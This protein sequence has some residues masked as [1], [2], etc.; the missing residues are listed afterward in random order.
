[1]SYEQEYSDVVDQVFT[2]LA[3]P[4]IRKL[5]I[6]VIQEYLHFI[7]P[8]EISPDLNKSLTKGNFES[9]A[10]HAHKWKEECEEK[11]N[12]AYD[13]ADISDDELDATDDRFRFSEA[14]ACIGAEPFTKNKLRF[15]I[16]S[17]STFKADPTVDILLELEKHL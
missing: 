14:C 3:I 16:D 8:E 11:L 15:F 13:Q 12:L 10:A 5:M 2:E 9:I 1:M 7:T 4:E 17:L 6:A